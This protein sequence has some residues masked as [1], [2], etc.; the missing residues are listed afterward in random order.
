L[1]KLLAR[2]AAKKNP[3]KPTRTP[4]PGPGSSSDREGNV[5]ISGFQSFSGSGLGKAGGEKESEFSGWFF[6]V[7][8]GGTLG[9]T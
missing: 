9:T 2:R 3:K 4:T 8:F 5:N 7:H 6:Q 1:K